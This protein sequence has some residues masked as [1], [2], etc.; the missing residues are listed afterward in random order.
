VLLTQRDLEVFLRQAINGVFRE[1]HIQD[2]YDFFVR[3]I[4]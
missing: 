1:S 4:S 3:S 2:R